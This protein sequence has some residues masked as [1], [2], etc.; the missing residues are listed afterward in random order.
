MISNHN[1]FSLV[2]IL[3]NRALHQPDQIAFTFLIDGEM[4][5]ISWTYKEL[6]ERARAIAA[7]LQDLKATGERALLLYPQGLEFIAAFFGCLYA[8]VIGVP[9]HPPRQNQ[10]SLRLQAIIT[11][12][13]AKIVLTTSTVLLNTS[14]QIAQSP[15]LKSLQ[16]IATENVAVKFAEQ[17]RQPLL[18]ADTL[19]FLQY[20]SGSTGVPKGVM[21]SH[22]NMM[23]N[24][25]M[26]QQAMQYTEKTIS[27][28]W[29]PLFHDMGLI[30]NILQPIYLGIPCILMSPVAFLQR[31]LCWLQAISR[32]RATTSGGPNFAYDLCTRKVTP[33]QR[34][35]L[36]LSS[37]DV[38][39]NG[40]EPVR[41]DV[42][43][44][45][46]EAF[47]PCGFRKSAFYPCYGMAET[48]LIVSGGLKA[49][50]PVFKN[51][52]AAS[53]EQNQVKSTE[54]EDEAVQTLV[55]CGKTLLEQKIVI[56]H[57]D[58]LTTCKP[59]E[60]GEIWVSGDNVA[61]G[62]WDRPE[63]TQH[64]FQ[65]FLAD[66]GEGPFLRTGDMGF[67]ADKE[68]FITGRLK[69]LIIIRGHNHYPQDIELTLEQSHPSLR[70]GYGAAFSVDVDGEER[71]VV[72]QEIER[73]YLQTLNVDDVA[74]AI[75][76][77]V[78]ENHGLQ[79]YAVL[80]LK[81]G[82]I[83]KT[84]SGKIQRHA[85]RNGFLLGSLNILGSSILKDYYSLWRE[86]SL[87]REALLET[88]P[89]QRQVL[90]E[91]Y[92]QEQVA[93]VLR[94]DRFQLQPQQSLS[95]VGLDS[96][97]AVDLKNGIETNLGVVLSMT[98]FLQGS[99]ITQ[100]VTEILTQLT[101]PISTLGIT[102]TPS[103]ETV[104]QHPVSYGQRAL[105]FLHQLAPE[106]S[107]YNIVRA[108]R[109]L[110][111]LD[112]PAL[113]RALQT[114]V[115]RHPSLRATFTTSCGKPV[116][117]V[118]EHIE[119]CFQKEDVSTWSEVALDEHL[120]EEAHR[121]FN[122][123][124]GPLLRVKLYTRSA[125]E[126]ILLLAMHHIVADFWSLSILLHELGTLYRTEK[127]GIPAT[128]APLTLQ[129]IDYSLWQAEMLAS[130]EGERLWAYWQ[131]QLAGELPVL[132]LLTDRPRP[133]IQ[134]YRGASVHFKL[135]ADLTQRL[136]VLGSIHGATLYMT[137]LAAFQVLLYRYT[138]Q[139]DFLVGSPTVGRSRAEFARLV[140]YFVNPVVL[141]A[142][143]AGNPTFSTYLEQVRQTVLAA[144]EHQD[145]PFPLLVEQLQPIRE[146]S[147]SP[148]FQ[149]MFILQKAHLLN[150]E[151]LAAFA[152][153]EAGSRI[154]LGGLELESLTLEQQVA[155]FDLT[156]MMAEVGEELAASL[157]YNTDIFDAATIV[158]MSGHFQ[159]LL[160]GIVAH[161]EQQLSGLPLLTEAERRLL[162]DWND[163][164][165]DYSKD[166]CIHELFE[167][168]V[169]RD[170]DA[171]AVVFEGEQLT[172][173]ELNCR[174]NQLAHYLK[175][176]GVEPE[177]LV[178]ICMERSLE[179]LV[180]LLGILK[181]GGAYLP[182]D[183]EY[184]QS[185]LAFMLEDAQTP[186]LL[187][188]AQWVE[189]LPKYKARIVC[190][191]TDW[192]VI[193][194]ESRENQTSLVKPGNLAY[195]IY[196]S[197]STGKPKGVQVMH[198]GLCNLALALQ[199]I[200]DVQPDNRVLQFA[201][202]S[203]DASVWEIF[204]ALV[205]GATLVL[206]TKDSLLP[207]PA[208]I[209]FLRNQAITTVLLPP[210]VLAVLHAEELPRLRTIIAGGEA[211]PLN[212][213]TRWAHGR[214]FFNAY[215]P[216]E[217]TVCATV[218]EC[219]CYGKKPPI[220]Y[221]IPNTKVYLMDDQLQ[222]VPVGVPGELHISGAGLARGYLNRPDLTAERFIP[223]PFSDKPESRLY[224]TG[225]L[226]RYLPDGNIEFLGRI[227]YQVKVRGF[228]IE[229]GEI[230]EVLNQHPGLQDT[231]VVAR[232][233]TQVSGSKLVAYVVPSP[234]Q[235]P[236]PGE[237]YR[238]LKSKLPDYMV[239]SAFILLETL[240][241]TPNGKV[242]RQALPAPAWVSLES[243]E[244]ITASH[245]LIQELLA[246]IWIKLLGVGSVGIHDNFFELGG[247]SLLAAQLI[248]RLREIFQIELPLQNLFEVPTIAGLA[249]YIETNCW[250]GKSLQV[251]PLQ[252]ISRNRN[253]PLS[254]S[255][256][257]SSSLQQFSSPVSHIPIGMYLTGTLNIAAL[258]H[259]LNEIIRRHEALRT[260][261]VNVEYQP[262]QV[263]IPELSLSLSVIALS[264]L[265]ENE[266]EAEIQRLVI[267]E[268]FRPFDLTQA[269]LLRSTLVQLS[270]REYVWLLTIHHMIF[271]GWSVGI[272]FKEMAVL[273]EAFS[274]CKP[275][276]LPELPIQYADFAYWQ[277][278]WMQSEVLH[279]HLDYWKKQLSKAP[280][281]L[282]LP[283]SQKG[284]LVKS[285]Q[286]TT[287]S[288]TVSTTLTNKLKTLS[289]EEGATIFISLLAIL[290][291]LLFH[292]T[293][294]EDILVGSP[295]AGRNRL[296]TEGLIGFFTNM[297]PLRTKLSGNPTF[298]ELLGRVR[299]VFL[300]AYAHQN[301]PF[302]KI[303]Q[304]LYSES[305][306]N[307]APLISVR[308]TFENFP[309]PTPTFSGLEVRQMDIDTGIA[310]GDLILFMHEK[311]H[312]I[313]GKWE[314]NSEL[315]SNSTIRQMI[316]T[317]QSLME[318][319]V[320]KPELRL[321]ELHHKE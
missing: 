307:L 270:A 292:Y 215:G 119:V 22:Q 68:L 94:V 201:S 57:P 48:T 265:A 44:K 234:H 133:P 305:E 192:K 309:L 26:I 216:T 80:L 112:I 8:G 209:N 286:R 221:P 182:L 247:H 189:S 105:W 232:E 219:T 143:F 17:W 135:N 114:L 40:A 285:S 263:V 9:A 227:D 159:T 111:D 250:A 51:V 171:I 160:E 134:T 7:Q 275:S 142:N 284:S 272:F 4:E 93:Q 264:D 78:I 144:F 58:T 98:S 185:R 110:T 60:V 39:F 294:Q 84:S 125:Q 311:E 117:R 148:L 197:G 167:A 24:Q 220:G 75:R 206:G 191:D 33:E 194:K 235:K 23:Y 287:Q 146:P 273:Y 257:R 236:T 262:E 296:E 318:I 32:Y 210:S 27:V 13:R 120:V 233:E 130:P 129:Y 301:L 46:S 83:P 10:S 104:D 315:F 218:A 141:R 147:Q 178:G 115:A 16:W 124:Q 53:L 20:T 151:G 107:A 268:I 310:K 280:Q 198:R 37:W 193:A 72:A 64:I 230:E 126:H 237:L 131:K 6:D 11:D 136:K 47:A 299:E 254:L 217:A 211:C 67:L 165:I 266:R 71:L 260:V 140:G 226:A 228:R 223:N 163:T 150:E 106:S 213:V 36:D 271:D 289:H 246:D 74:R 177:V 145:Y 281:P 77:A 245:T 173:Q 91:S 290:K 1:F 274:N 224:K 152:L 2:H 212:L 100:L 187:T 251:P 123:E 162:V 95:T 199:S 25:Q 295:V 176:L 303:K 175:T 214:R 88:D 66:T 73:Q 205:A 28:G 168:Q 244:T 172:Y 101:A 298:R 50:L 90:L 62:Y 179:M 45:F 155:Q 314:Y 99:S 137:L 181:A 52:C 278:R 157:Q 132:N 149:I 61:Q 202:L 76:Q 87:T 18:K 258:E 81:T 283:T 319:V 288:F 102:L 65:A 269:P 240:P 304:I 49:A 97:M 19:A 3:C 138:G 127:E 12:A 118:H 306:P 113:Q 276:P 313:I 69:D 282:K 56:A 252:P 116:Q 208:L 55:G 54:S 38:A 188:Q 302:S 256:Q 89:E 42:I 34:E 153:E 300:G 196:T 166:V 308:F 238:F 15:E 225:D 253:L 154:E 31:P 200:F 30:G 85:C 29:L 293:G 63:E 267:E 320:S 103:Q 174:V 317:Y 96:L 109:I 186:V 312:E 279:I 184:P 248:S 204:M 231:V 243:E 161:P 249:Q 195:I 242:D 297:L 92:F 108:V 21:V 70:R 122:L 239:P 35:N 169:K 14:Q 190:L 241:L 5:K 321:S 255:Q 222:L 79:V 261:F 291:T 164:Q 82:S 158:R 41:A 207:G 128:L 43:E 86:H 277:Q 139:E 170:P 259:S 229:L 180:G 156:L 59:N 203:F 316:E 183:P 121:P